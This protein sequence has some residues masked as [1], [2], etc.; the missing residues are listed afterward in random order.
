MTLGLTMRRLRR[1]RQRRLSLRELY[2]IVK[3]RY[4][5]EESRRLSFGMRSRVRILERK[6]PSILAE[7]LKLC[8]KLQVVL[9][10][11]RLHRKVKV[12]Y[13]QMEVGIET[14]R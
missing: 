4:C 9:K 6:V 3:L 13:N 14:Q 1:N 11:K 12:T 8:K 10:F 7:L 5:R 2:Q